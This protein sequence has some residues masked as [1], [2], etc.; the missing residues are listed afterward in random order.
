MQGQDPN[1]RSTTVLSE[2]VSGSASFLR[3]TRPVTVGALNEATMLPHM[4][5][6]SSVEV[7][8]VSDKAGPRDGLARI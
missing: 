3:F 8:S 7:L 4:V 6:R 2:V 5:G 1:E